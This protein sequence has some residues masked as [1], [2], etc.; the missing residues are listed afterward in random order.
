MTD[1]TPIAAPRASTALITLEEVLLVTQVAQVALIEVGKEP[2]EAAAVPGALRVTI[3]DFSGP[4]GEGTGNRPLPDHTTLV[5]LLRRGG[6]TPNTHVVVYAETAR[7]LAGAARAWVVLR[8]AG[9]KAVSYLNDAHAADLAALA[10]PLADARHNADHEPFVPDHSVVVDAATVAGRQGG[11]LL[12]DARTAEAYGDDTQHIPGAVNVPSSLL[13]T[14]GRIKPASEVKD[15][16][17]DALGIDPG[18]R[19]VI[20]YC[21]SGVSASV[22]SLA[23]G[24]LGIA[25]PVYIGS[26][27]EWS[28]RTPAVEV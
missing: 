14:S 20:L 13:A 21:G 18:D 9:I 12:I 19:P 8:W 28:K 4:E 15:A 22:Q 26:W 1:T 25:A 11:A 16:Y 23:L 10:I 2:A 27:S 17:V 6:I 5:R 24:A 7:D 3:D